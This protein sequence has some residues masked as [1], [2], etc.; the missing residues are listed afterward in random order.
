[1]IDPIVSLIL[2]EASMATENQINAVGLRAKIVTIN[3][4]NTGAVAQITTDVK[5]SAHAEAI[6]KA[7]D[8]G[9]DTRSGVRAYYVTL[10][11]SGVFGDVLTYEAAYFQK[12]IEPKL[13]LTPQTGDENADEGTDTGA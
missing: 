12:V 9:S 7:I 8:E 6:A 13:V 1:M 2:K 5:S 4:S 10:T 11:G 3:N